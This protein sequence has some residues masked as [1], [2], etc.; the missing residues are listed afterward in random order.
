MPPDVA[1]DQLTI[2]LVEFLDVRMERDEQTAA[3]FPSA[4]AK[5]AYDS[6][7]GGLNLVSP[8]S[9]PHDDRYEI[10]SREGGDASQADFVV[11]IVEVAGGKDSGSFRETIHVGRGTT[12]TG[13]EGE[14]LVVDA[15]RESGCRG[16]HYDHCS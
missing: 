14:A 10:L 15:R 16:G 1:V 3:T 7:G 5:R 13:A 8:T 12:Y 9:S 11:R 2:A 6:N 4:A